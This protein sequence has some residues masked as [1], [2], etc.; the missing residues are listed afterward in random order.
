MV[1][2]FMANEPLKGI[3]LVE[4]TEYKTKKDWAKFV[5]RIVDEMYPNAKKIKLVMDNFKTHSASA[6]YETFEPDEAKRIWDKLELIYTPKHGKTKGIIKTRRLTGSLQMIRQ[7]S[8]LKY[9][10]RQFQ[11]NITLL[12]FFCFVALIGDPY[13]HTLA[14]LRIR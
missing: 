12:M 1:N 4:I 2:I 9:F 10:I 14:D 7:G 13:Q 8:N 6:F 5:K 3:R 11:I